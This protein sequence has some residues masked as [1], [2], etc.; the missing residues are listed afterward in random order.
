MSGRVPGRNIQSG[1]WEAS[2]KG[3]GNQA[4]RDS[5][6]RVSRACHVTKWGRMRAAGM[7]CKACRHGQWCALTQ[8]HRCTRWVAQW[9][10]A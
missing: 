10:R 8:V 9:A 4:G 7:D 6:M 5:G 1:E 3:E 2:E